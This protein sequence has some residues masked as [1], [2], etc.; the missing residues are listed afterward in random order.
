MRHAGCLYCGGTAQATLPHLG[1]DL[2]RLVG[3]PVRDHFLTCRCRCCCLPGGSVPPMDDT[4]A[5]QDNRI[6]VVDASTLGMNAV[7]GDPAAAGGSSTIP[8]GDSS[9]LDQKLA[10]AGAAATSQPSTPQQQFQQ[11]VGVLV[12][13]PTCLLCAVSSTCSCVRL[14]WPACCVQP[15]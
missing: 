3:V 6:R 12:V 9:L 10:A 4:V 5:M 15:I 11:Q 14:V 13:L 1:S 8:G 2:Q 7:N